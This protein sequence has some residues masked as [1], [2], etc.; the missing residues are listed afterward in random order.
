MKLQEKQRGWDREN[1][2]GATVDARGAGF[3]EKV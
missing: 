1:K 2:R 3:K